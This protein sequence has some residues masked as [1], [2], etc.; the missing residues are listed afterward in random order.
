MI[1]DVVRVITIAILLTKMSGSKTNSKIDN[2]DYI[3]WQPI[4][5]G[6]S[7]SIFFPRDQI[8]QWINNSNSKT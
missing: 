1:L 4:L 6:R 2:T 8:Y 7:L 3:K 5:E